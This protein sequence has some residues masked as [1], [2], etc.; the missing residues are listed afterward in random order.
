M[1]SR[2]RE[3]RTVEP[4]PN[5]FEQI[6][7]RPRR[8]NLSGLRRRRT[9]LW[10]DGGLRSRWGLGGGL[11]LRFAFKWA[12]IR[13]WIDLQRRLRQLYGQ[14]QELEIFDLAPRGVCVRLSIPAHEMVRAEEVPA[15]LTVP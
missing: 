14:G 8:S 3:R 5:A 2:V 9:H 11:N 13:M 10:H 1:A 4:L 15:A 6:G 7:L 12:A